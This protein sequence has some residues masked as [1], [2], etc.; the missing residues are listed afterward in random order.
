MGNEGVR[1]RPA[2]DGG[3]WRCY[4]EGGGLRVS[5]VKIANFAIFSFLLTCTNTFVMKYDKE[6]EYYDEGVRSAKREYLKE[7]MMQVVQSAIQPILA[8]IGSRSLKEFNEAFHNAI[9]K[10][11]ATKKAG[12]NC[13]EACLKSFDDRCADVI[14]EQANCKTYEDLQREILQCAID[15]LV[16][17]QKK[18]NREELI[19]VAAFGAGALVGGA[20]LAC[21]VP[22]DTAMTMANVGKYLVGR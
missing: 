11:K 1:K 7:R 15:G 13:K 12:H 20:A 9:E 19:E 8:N 5:S 18:K 21:G 17:E 14:V 10:G 4:R 6:T 16:K 3:R 2:G 22:A